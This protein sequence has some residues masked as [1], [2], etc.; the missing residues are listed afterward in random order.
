MITFDEL[1]NANIERKKEKVFPSH[2]WSLAQW[3]CAMAGECGEACNIIK[4]MFR[5]DFKC[6]DEEIKAN[7]DLADELAD[8]VIY[9]DLTAE[10][11]GIDLG[12]AIKNKFNKVS[13]KRGA[14]VKL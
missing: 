1:R 14:K 11:A 4:K 3:A 2:N 10:K 6:L 7:L 5:G 8:L 12:E 9:V 13:E